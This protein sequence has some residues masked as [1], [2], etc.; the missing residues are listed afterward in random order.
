MRSGL[1]CWD[2]AWDNNVVKGRNN[3]CNPG[4]KVAIGKGLV[5]H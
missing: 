1:G 2:V 3:G 4:L 5:G